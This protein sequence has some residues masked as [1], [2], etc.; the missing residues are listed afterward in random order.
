MI[1]ITSERNN[2]DK[3]DNSDNDGAYV[4]AQLYSNS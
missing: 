1:V 4:H 2:N 3:S